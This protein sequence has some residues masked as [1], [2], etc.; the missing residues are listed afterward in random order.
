MNGEPA[1][2]VHGEALRWLDKAEEDRRSA[3]HL[4]SL[5][6]PVPDVVGFH[7]QQA[8]EKMLKAL[9]ILVGHEV[10]KLHDLDVLIRLL[11]PV[12][13]LPPV[14]MDAVRDLTPWA[15]AGRDPALG[16]YR[17]P[18][19]EELI[20]AQDAVDRLAGFVAARLHAAPP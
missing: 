8:A 1:P 4:M 2:T 15:V 20:T 16:R 10:P 9:L 11:E 13:V 18:S 6:P 12:L 3:R 14:L 5:V 17:G 19:V 7:L